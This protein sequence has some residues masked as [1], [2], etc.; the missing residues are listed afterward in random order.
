MG[1]AS[2]KE[3]GSLPGKLSLSA[4]S[5]LPSTV[6]GAFW[7]AASGRLVFIFWATTSCSS[8]FRSACS[9]FPASSA[10]A[11]FWAPCSFSVRSFSLAWACLLPGMGVSLAGNEARA[12]H[13]TD[14]VIAPRSRKRASYGN[15]ESVMRLHDIRRHL[16]CCWGVGQARRLPSHLTN[17]ERDHETPD[18]SGHARGDC[19][20]C[21]GS[22]RFR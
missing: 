1:A 8:S 16:G 13:S 17:L 15:G 22:C 5:S 2:R 10:F 21:R 4:L 11:A 6:V 14:K 3:T 7:A 9:S 18:S 19:N 12:A 20:L